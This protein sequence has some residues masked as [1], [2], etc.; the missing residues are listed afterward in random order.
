MSISNARLLPFVKYIVA[1]TPFSFGQKKNAVD[2]SQNLRRG[3][4]RK[5]MLPYG[6]IPFVAW[7]FHF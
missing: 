1:A 3:R 7:L 4:M 2:I 6:N 5:G